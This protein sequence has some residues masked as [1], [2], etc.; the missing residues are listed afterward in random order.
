MYEDL[1]L[2]QKKILDFI[3]DEIDGRGYPP[4][5]REICDSVGL[6]SSSSA[7]YQLNKLE[8][9][10]YI[11]KDPSKTRAMEIIKG[12][13]KRTQRNSYDTS[14]NEEIVNVPIIGN[15]TAGEPILA[16]EEYSETFPLPCSFTHNS[17]CFI[18]NVS[19][20]SMINAGIL[21]G[22]YVIVKQQNTANNGDIVVALIEDSATVKTFYKEQNRVRLQPENPMLEPIYTTEVQILG[23]VVGVIRKM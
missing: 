22:D 11:R 12:E 19:G 10:G 16:Y 20:T 21:D 2:I 4:S 8:S 6:A 9:K 15:V 18:L 1:T 14:N 17:Q 7:H 23:K 5:V 13:T 3:S